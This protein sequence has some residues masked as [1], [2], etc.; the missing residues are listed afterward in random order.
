MYM[1]VAKFGDTDEDEPW[2]VTVIGGANAATLKTRDEVV[3]FIEEHAPKSAV[4]LANLVIQCEI[5]KIKQTLCPAGVRLATSS[6]FGTIERC[7]KT[8]NRCYDK[9]LKLVKTHFSIFLKIAAYEALGAISVGHHNFD[10]YQCQLEVTF[11]V[12]HPIQRRICRTGKDE[13]HA[14]LS[15]LKTAIDIIEMG[16]MGDTRSLFKLTQQLLDGLMTDVKLKR[17]KR[18]KECKS[19]EAMVAGIAIGGECPRGRE[20]FDQL[21]RISENILGQ[22]D[23]LQHSPADDATLQHSDYDVAPCSRIQI[24]QLEMADKVR[25]PNIFMMEPGDATAARARNLTSSDP[26]RS[27]RDAAAWHPPEEGIYEILNFSSSKLVP[28]AKGDFWQLRKLDQEFE[29]RIKPL[30]TAATH[31]EHPWAVLGFEFRKTYQGDKKYLFV[32]KP[33][34]AM[35]ELY[36]HLLILS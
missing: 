7:F 17:R 35:A 21:L 8:P 4:E 25:V 32:S 10:G 15:C 2:I 20:R 1:G 5:H 19:I 33:D 3:S 34:P 27:I 22:D 26:Q 9:F 13:C 30:T 24:L 6:R 23:T 31:G 16:Q 29:L 28:V 12:D 36:A 18:T 11:R 14:I